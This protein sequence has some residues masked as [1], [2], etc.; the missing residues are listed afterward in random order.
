M[1]DFAMQ[2]ISG[3]EVI[4][5]VRSF[6]PD[7][8][9]LLITGYSDTDALAEVGPDIPVLRKPF[10]AETLLTATRMAIGEISRTGAA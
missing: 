8:P 2:G 7:L 10:D 4:K 3:A 6:R 1:V 5:S 9:I